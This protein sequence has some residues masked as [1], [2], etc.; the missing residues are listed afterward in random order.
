M[1]AERI[2]MREQSEAIEKQRLQDQARMEAERAEI[3]REQEQLR[4]EAEER[5]EAER[6]RVLA[7]RRA[8]EEWELAAKQAAEEAARVARLEALRPEIEKAEMFGDNLMKGASLMLDDLG[9]PFWKPQAMEAVRRCALE[10][11]GIARGEA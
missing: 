8:A 3:R 11:L 10:V 5:A 9:S 4:R 6:Q 1:E 7:E 2:R